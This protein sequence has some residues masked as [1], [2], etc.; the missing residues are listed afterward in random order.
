MIL[1]VPLC[2]CRCAAAGKNVLRKEPMS[3]EVEESDSFTFNEAFSS[4]LYK[5]KIGTVSAQKEGEVEKQ[6]T[7]HKV[8]QRGGVQAG[9]LVGLEL[10]GRLVAGQLAKCMLVI[11]LPA[12][13]HVSHFYLG[14]GCLGGCKPFPVIP[15]LQY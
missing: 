15:A 5:I 2:S 10:W 9:F 11:Q 4:K 12:I 3:K 14:V 8:R 13:S 7:R 6:E 1:A